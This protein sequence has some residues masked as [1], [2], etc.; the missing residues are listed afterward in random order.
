[1]GVA[2]PEEFRGD[3]ALAGEWK[4]V[5]ERVIEE[6]KP[7][8]SSS[9]AAAVGVRKRKLEN[10]EEEEHA[11]V[12]F[13]SKGWGS[14]VRQYPG[15]QGDEDLDALL[16]STKEIKKVKPSVPNAVDTTTKDVVDTP[17]KTEGDS[18]APETDETSRVKKEEE[19]PSDV[20]TSSVP[21]VKAESE[22]AAAP[23]VVF[24]KRRPKAMRK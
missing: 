2:I 23:G 22:E 21:A 24:K 9:A 5:S 18:T 3:M 6:E 15:S 19:E 7:K 11:P 4:T 1:M 16:E 10:G 13:V 20:A 12:R 14:A 8:I 17:V